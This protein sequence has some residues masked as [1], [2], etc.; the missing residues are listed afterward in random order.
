MRLTPRS[1][2]GEHRHEM[3]QAGAAGKPVRIMHLIYRL[4]GGGMEHNVVKL[5]NAHDRSQVVPSICSCQPADSLK[6]HLTT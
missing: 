3:D 1:L 4:A 5:A 2:A 6:E